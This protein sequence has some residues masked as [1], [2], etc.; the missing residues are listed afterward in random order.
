MVLTGWIQ[1]TSGRE[2]LVALTENQRIELELGKLVCPACGKACAPRFA[3]EEM[4]EDLQV[5]CW[6][7]GA[8]K[9]SFVLRR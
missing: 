1:C 7:D 5:T 8:W 9:K 3:P 6:K 2:E 4:S